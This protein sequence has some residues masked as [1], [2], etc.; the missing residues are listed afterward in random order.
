M[1]LSPLAFPVIAIVAGCVTQPANEWEGASPFDISTE[2]VE[3]RI[4]DN[5]AAWPVAYAVSGVYTV[6]PENN[7]IHF[8]ID[9]FAM[10]VTTNKSGTHYVPH[11]IKSLQ[12]GYCYF[13]HNDI[14]E[15]VPS[16]TVRVSDHSA[17]V[18]IVVEHLDEVY[19]KVGIA[20]VS[21]LLDTA[22]DRKKAWPCSAL[23]DVSKGSLG[24]IPAQQKALRSIE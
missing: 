14:Y 15:M 9:K 24:Y 13:T 12:I 22:I 1:K 23:W 6:D 2:F 19:S 4:N 3:A 7:R 10:K 8:R 11:D 5:P 18:G 17:P 20:S 21:V 16:P